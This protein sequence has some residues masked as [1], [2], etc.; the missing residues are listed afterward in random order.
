MQREKGKENDENLV[1]DEI[2]INEIIDYIFKHFDMDNDG[3]INSLSIDLSQFEAEILEAIKDV[4]I[5]IDDNK[6]TVDCKQ[7]SAIIKKLQIEN[8][9][10]EV[11]NAIYL[12]N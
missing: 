9:L 8:Q 10:L 5:Y 6:L 11:N 4:L 2:G 12:R 7:F 3:L 1:L